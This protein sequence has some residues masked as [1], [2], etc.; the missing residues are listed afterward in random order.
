M[1]VDLGNELAE[2]VSCLSD[3]EERGYSTTM[4]YTCYRHPGSRRPLGGRL[5][6]T[7]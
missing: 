6:G 2:K 3:K 4:A 7:R 5:V 1:K